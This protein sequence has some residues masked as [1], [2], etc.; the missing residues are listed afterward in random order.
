MF[1]PCVSRVY[2]V[3]I[4]HDLRVQEIYCSLT[5]RM[6]Y[7]ML[8]S[9]P[10]LPDGGIAARVETGNHIDRIAKRAEIK[11]VWKLPQACAA[12]IGQHHRKLCWF[13]EDALNLPV[14]LRA[15]PRPEAG[16]FVFIPILCFD[17]LQPGGRHEDHGPGHGAR[18]ASSALSC[19]HVTAPARSRSKFSRRRSSSA[20]CAAVRRTSSSARLSQSAPIKASRSGGLSRAIS[21]GVITLMKTS[22][23]NARATCKPIQSKNLSGLFPFLQP[24]A[25]RRRTSPL[26]IVP[27]QILAINRR[28]QRPPPAPIPRPQ[29]AP[30]V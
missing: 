12:Y 4:N 26:R 27:G 6:S 30:R 19:S 9:K 18:L 29:A 15:K 10:A 8:R 20:A 13:G 2:H 17:C 16:R 25:A 11:S 28:K 14:K 24:F 7:Q 1:E 3:R 23:P 5:Q 22:Y 21:S